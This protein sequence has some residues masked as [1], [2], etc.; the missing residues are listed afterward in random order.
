MTYEF[1][2][3]AEQEYADAANWYEDQ[4]EG[5]GSRFAT[6]IAESILTILKEPG[7]FQCLEDGL[8]VFRLNRWPYK[9]YYEYNQA[10]SH[11]RIVCVMH[12]KRQPEYWIDRL[13]Q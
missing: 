2:P 4:V 8:R 10:D 3:A 5:L 9:L 6:A 1:H 12:Q 7:R 11:L 13:G